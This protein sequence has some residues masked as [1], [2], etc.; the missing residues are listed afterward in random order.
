VTTDSYGDIYVDSFGNEAEHGA[1]GRI[2]IFDSEG[3]FLTEIADSSGPK[4]LA[5]DS[6]GNLYVFNYRASVN[7]EEV[8]RYSPTTYNPEAGEIEY[9]SAVQV[10][11]GQGASITGIAINRANDHLFVHFGPHLTEYGSAAEGNKVIDETIGKGIL[12]LDAPAMGLAVDAAHGRIYATDHRSSPDNFVIRALDLASPHALVLTIDGSTT[13]AGKFLEG[14]LSV[15]VDEGTGHVFVYDE[16]AKV[17][18]EFTEEGQYVSTIEHSFEP[19]FGGEISI[20]NGSKSPNGVLNPVGRY[21]YVPSKPSGVGHSFAFGPQPPIGPPVVE[22]VSFSEVTQTEAELEATINPEGIPTEYIFEYTSREDF[23]AEGF[24]GAQIAGEGELSGGNLGIEVSAPA[25]GL[26]P[27]TSYV[28]R[29]LATNEEGPDEGEDSFTTYAAPGPTPECSND[30]LRVGLSALL[31]DCRAY[32]L[33]TPADTDSRTPTGVW[34]LGTYFATRESSPT[35]EK[36]SF[37]VEG[38]SIPGFEGTGSLAG[39]PYLATRGADGWKTTAAGPDGT[40]AQAPLLGS[41]SPDQGF[42][43]WSSGAAG[44][45]AIEGAETT[46]V[47][48]PDGH[49]ALVGRGSVADDTQAD[50]KLISENGG[51]IIFAT[52]DFGGHTAVQLEEDAPPSGTEAIYD[53]TSDEVTHVVSLRPGDVTPAAGENAFYQG[54]SLDG[55]GVAFK[56]GGGTPTGPLYLRYDDEETY[57][58]AAEATFAGI[59]EGG[60]RIFYLKGGD[61]YAF[62]IESEETLRFTESGDVTVVNVSA[63]GSGAYVVSPSILSGEENPN[64][65]TAQAGEE[66]LYL[67]R[68]GVVSFVGTVTERDVEGVPGNEQIDGLGLWVEAVGPGQPGKDPSRTTPDGSVM[69]F[70]SRADLAGYDP[71]GHAEVYR[72]DSAGDELACLS[73]NPTEAPATGQASLE[74]IGIS[75]DSQEPFSAFGYVANLRADG[76]RAFFQSTEALVPGDT[77]GLQDVYEWEAQGV[78]SC[79]RPQGCTYLISS[80]QSARTDYLYAVSDSGDDVF[81][82]SSDLLVPSDND[83][84]PSIYD[85]R[86]GGGFPEGTEEECLAEGC[87]GGLIPGPALP[88]PAA[89]AVSADDNVSVA[90]KC[91]KGKHKVTKNGK[92]RCVKKHHKRRHRKAGS[93]QRGAG[94]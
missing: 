71:E 90:K 75:I 48:Y 46:Y 38:G 7:I 81:F 4:N 79:E 36:V 17:V 49:S 37:R 14:R 61:L 43:F 8:A 44:S 23:E 30:A 53:R 91:P 58:V 19:V 24:A 68:E 76:R 55:K 42:S 52:K 41:T 72:Y 11:P 21:L 86:V 77:D 63:D 47:R 80:G 69:L 88:M 67:S 25:V 65:D 70:E 82:R 51:H 39:D 28:F 16:S 94:K 29:V 54:A 26:S 2:D 31:P 64:G 33:V 20:D 1:A 57:E 40:E 15:A 60:K 83:E 13:P 59:A 84:T 10:A 18:Y 50:G 62:D 85:A 34:R 45:A 78:G 32:E 89:P 66:N 3:F 12:R 74:S 27:G 56:L 93:K 35:G 92:T 6:E 5:V 73:C 22:S 87:R 9:G